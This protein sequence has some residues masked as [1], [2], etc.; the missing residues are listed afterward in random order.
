MSEIDDKWFALGGPG[1]FLGQPVDEGAGSGEMSTRSGA[2]RCRDFQGGSIYFKPG[3]GAFEVHGDIRVKWAQ[4]GGESSFLGFPV[5]DETGT[6]NGRGRYNH[7][8]GGSI[9]WTP[10]HRAH[11]VWGDIRQRWAEMGWERSRLGFPT[12]DER[13]SGQPGG[14]LTDFEGG[15]ILWTPPHNLDVRFRI[16]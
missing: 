11:V 8:E 6:P 10:E 9:Y 15:V 3:I 14:R 4:Y 12:S 16:D 5:T 7:F 2:G 13:D 1:G